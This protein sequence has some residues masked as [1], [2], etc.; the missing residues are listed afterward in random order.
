MTAG[1]VLGHLVHRGGGVDVAGAECLTQRGREH[2]AGQGV[3]V[4]VAQVEGDR[5]PAVRL[6][7]PG[8]PVVHGRERLV[9]A[10][11]LPPV[12]PA[13]SRLADPV[14][15]GIQMAEARALR[16][17]VAAAERVV[18]VAAH[19]GDLVAVHGQLQP[20]CRLAQRAGGVGQ[21]HAVKLP[22]RRRRGW[23]TSSPGQVPCREGGGRRRPGR[24]RRAPAGRTGCGRAPRTDR[25]GPAGRGG[26]RAPP[27]GRPPAPG[28][29]RRS[30]SSTAGAR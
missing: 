14:G 26:G 22:R 20:A 21:R 24:V 13:Q 17:Q 6:D 9:P 5:V 4:R 7:D 30:G 27:P 8:Q 3:H 1:D 19:A 15:V 12:A 11:R 29:G 28:S 16:A 2:P 23:A 18:A 25:R 10:D